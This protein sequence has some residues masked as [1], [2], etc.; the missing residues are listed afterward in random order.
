VPETFARDYVSKLD[1]LKIYATDRQSNGGVPW[2]MG[3]PIL[4]FLV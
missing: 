4:S 3:I 1:E 2:F